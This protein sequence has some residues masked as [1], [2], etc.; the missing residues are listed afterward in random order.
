MRV[1][2]SEAKEQNSS[3]EFLTDKSFNECP[4]LNSEEIEFAL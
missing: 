4:S 2:E 3:E 1:A